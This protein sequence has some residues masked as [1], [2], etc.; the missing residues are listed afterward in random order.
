MKVALC[1]IAKMENRYINEFVEHYK[2]LG[3]DNIFIYDNN[4]INGEKVSDAIME[5]IDSGFAKVI[6]YRGK[7]VCQLMAYRDCYEKFNKQYDWIAFFDCDEFLEFTDK[8]LNIKDFLSFDYFL[9]THAVHINW[10]IYDDNDLLEYDD[11]PLN[12]RFTRPRLPLDFSDKS[13]YDYPANGYYKT[14]LRCKLKNLI[15]GRDPHY[16][17]IN[18][19][20]IAK[21]P[22]GKNCIW[23]FSIFRQPEFNICYLKHF[24]FKSIQE[25]VEVKMQRLYPDQLDYSAKSKLKLERFFIY[26]DWTQEKEDYAKRLLE[27]SSEI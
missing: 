9:D 25:Y 5:H 3:F 16:L 14:I 6:D 26:N 1:C 8:S 18:P 7:K 19:N 23:N 11:L 22:S 21:T 17:T 10:K 4:D 15:W 24:M 2:K 13:Y 20:Y 12:K 27:E